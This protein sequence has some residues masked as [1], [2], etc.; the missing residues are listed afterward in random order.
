MF[1]KEFSPLYYTYEVW[2]T[3]KIIIIYYY[4]YII[5]FRLGKQVSLYWFNSIKSWLTSIN[6]FC[7]QIS[8]YCTL[9]FCI[10]LNLD[11][12]ISNLIL[13]ILI[14]TNLGLIKSW[15]MQPIGLT[16]NTH[17]WKLVNN[18][19]WKYL[20]YYINTHTRIPIKSEC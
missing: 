6:L 12:F 4:N 14:R 1:C 17:S 18:S 3:C 16:F 13:L 5:Y 11:L 7:K 15:L 19:E 2:K 8:F 10:I 9:A 20:I